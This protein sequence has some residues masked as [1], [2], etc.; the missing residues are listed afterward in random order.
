[1]I[2]V[3]LQEAIGSSSPMK[4]VKKRSL[5][6]SSTRNSPMSFRSLSIR[7][8]SSTETSIGEVWRTA[9]FL[10]VYKA[11]PLYVPPLNIADVCRI[12]TISHLHQRPRFPGHWCG[13]D[14]LRECE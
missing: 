9:W 11:M 13:L 7:E 1:M 10:Y 3:F 6:A 5:L 4:I 2:N 12:D 8:T 14:Y